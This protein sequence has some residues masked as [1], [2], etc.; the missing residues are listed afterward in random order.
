MTI[1]VSLK[2]YEYVNHTAD[3]EFRSYGKDLNELFRNSFLALF[4]T[5][6]EVRKTNTKAIKRIT[7]TESAKDLEELMWYA[8]QDAISLSDANDLFFYDA[9]VVKLVTTGRRALKAVLY[10]TFT[11]PKKLG[12]DIKAVSRYNLKIT[13]MKGG[14][15]CTVVVDV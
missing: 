8:L 11:K 10:G 5:I 14:Y 6:A 13:K 4:N 3:V 12:F 2:K 15:S 7:I 9:D 1:G